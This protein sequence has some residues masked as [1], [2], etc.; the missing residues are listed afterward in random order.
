MS[1][2]ASLP[3]AVT[4]RL[5]PSTNTS[6]GP[7]PATSV[8]AMSR[9]AAAAAAG[10]AAGL[11]PASTTNFT[12]ANAPSTTAAIAMPIMTSLASDGFFLRAAVTSIA[13]TWA[14]P[15][16]PGCDAIGVAA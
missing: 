4:P 11:S 12:T 8:T 15:S 9:L 13:G 6:A 5:T 16:K 14:V 7:P 10:L 3:S 1:A 2:S